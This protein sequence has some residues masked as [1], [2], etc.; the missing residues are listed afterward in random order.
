VLNDTSHSAKEIIRLRAM[1]IALMITPCLL[2]S[3]SGNR[4]MDN[5]K[6]IPM[7]EGRIARAI[8][9]HLTTRPDE[10][11]NTDDL[12][13]VCYPGQRIERKHRDWRARRP[14]SG[15]LRF[16]NAASVPSTATVRHKRRFRG[17]AEQ[18]V[19]WD[20]PEVKAEA[21]RDVAEHLILRDGTPEERRLV[22][23][24][25]EARAAVRKA[26]LSSL[27]RTARSPISVLVDDNRAM[28]GD[29]AALA[30]KARALITENDPDA[31]RDGLAKLAAALDGIAR[32][33]RDPMETIRERLA[34]STARNDK[35]AA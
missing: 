23:A 13:G 29:L 18:P 6:A 1:S 21:E 5:M 31:I 22:A 7:R 32:E 27:A 34:I 2:L 28:G 19:P 9:E 35:S 10:A 33:M 26:Q 24:R 11:F 12:C 15:L 25:Q 20:R 3:A 16:F 17:R 4:D 8:R 30:E 14:M